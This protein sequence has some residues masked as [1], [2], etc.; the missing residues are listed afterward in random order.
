MR[1]SLLAFLLLFFFV[2]VSGRLLDDVPDGKKAPTEPP[3]GAPC[4]PN[5]TRYGVSLNVTISRVLSSPKV[6][7][8]ADT[9]SKALQA[10]FQL[11][12]SA[13]EMRRDTT[14][15]VKDICPAFVNLTSI[16]VWSGYGKH[17]G[18]NFRAIICSKDI[19]TKKAV[20]DRDFCTFYKE[21]QSSST[22]TLELLEEYPKVASVFQELT[23]MGGDCEMKCGKG[24]K[25]V[26]CNAFFVLASLLSMKDT[27]EQESKIPNQAKSG[28]TP[29]SAERKGKTNMVC[30][31]PP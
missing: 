10:M 9:I 4:L 16:V 15:S 8:C 20:E 19:L 18:P 29:T 11:D 31:A 14:D 13:E 17:P 6:L 21:Y 23:S 1:R 24:S 25:R 27:I 7:S 2:L 28:S 22:T 26:L 12:V 5:L 3:Q 30:A